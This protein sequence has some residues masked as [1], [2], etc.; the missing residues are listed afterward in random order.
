MAE[1]LILKQ[2]DT[3][4]LK[5]RLKEKG[6]G[7]DIIMGLR[8]ARQQ[9]VTM[10][11]PSSRE[12]VPGQ[13]RRLSPFPEAGVVLYPIST[14]GR[15]EQV[16]ALGRE[17]PSD[18][19]EPSLHINL[20]DEKGAPSQLMALL[21]VCEDNTVEIAAVDGETPVMM[22]RG[23]GDW[24]KIEALATGNEWQK[25]EPSQVND[26]K[27]YS[28]GGTLL[29]FNGQ[30]Y[31]IVTLP[32][33]SFAGN[34]EPASLALRTCPGSQA[35][36]EIGR[37]VVDKK[38]G[39]PVIVNEKGEINGKA[40]NLDDAVKILFEEIARPGQEKKPNLT[41]Q[42][43]ACWNTD[44]AGTLDF[45]ANRLNED[46][47]V[48]LQAWSNFEL[49]GGE[50]DFSQRNREEYNILDVL[51]QAQH[52]AM[53]QQSES[54]RTINRGILE[55]VLPL[56]GCG[57]R[58]QQEDEKINRIGMEL[59]ERRSKLNLGDAP[60]ILAMLERGVI[61]PKTGKI[62]IVKD[63]KA[64]KGEFEIDGEAARLDE[65]FDAAHHFLEDPKNSD[66]VEAIADLRAY[67]LTDKKGLLQ[68]LERKLDDQK[69]IAVLAQEQ[70]RLGSFF[71]F[72][73]QVARGNLEPLMVG[74]QRNPEA[75]RLPFE[76]ADGAIEMPYQNWLDVIMGMR[77]FAK[78]YSEEI[79][80]GERDHV[81]HTLDTIVLPMLGVAGFNEIENR[82][83][84]IWKGQV[85]KRKAKLV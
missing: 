76:T 30:V 83:M 9:T 1:Q 56:L 41:E 68:F 13:T 39:L 5:N 28:S 34:R 12:T 81:Q 45:L 63:P 73:G 65:K 2:I 7:G 18:Q 15:H 71:R 52:E 62:V 51:F 24:G 23:D 50:S 22:K 4:N 75:I 77:E 42:I 3:A 6:V 11:P 38:I 25:V 70:K 16:F 36:E 37:E 31:E 67:Y 61:E 54:A 29:G 27:E 69:L 49:E 79:S 80:R 44:R 60:E 57:T 14:G 32:K 55:I 58:S 20:G 48:N 59:W 35:P 47:F 8:W 43:K 40:S 78:E 46:D 21:K 66:S 84:I 19:E 53:S 26:Q 74:N 85:A 82:S 17:H 72:D 64:D 10:L 33:I